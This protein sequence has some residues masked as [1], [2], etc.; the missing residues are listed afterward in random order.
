MGLR[1]TGLCD[2]GDVEETAAHTEEPEVEPETESLWQTVKGDF[3]DAAG[4]RLIGLVL[5]FS[6]MAFQ[7][8]WGN[9]IL[10][11]PIVVRAYEAVDDG[12]GWLSGFAAIASGVGAGSLFWALT[13]ALD[14]VVVLSGLRLMPGITARISRFLRRQ[15]W[16]K[17]Y[18]DISLGTRFLIAYL[19][20]ASALALVDVFATGQPGLKH[21]WRLI[22]DAVALA[23]AGVAF[24]IFVVGLDLVVG[25]RVP[26]TE[27]AADVVLRF[28]RNP[29]TWLVIYG[30]GVLISALVRRLRPQES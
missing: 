24:A 28:A 19:S 12:V 4:L 9:D 21:R 25:S 7:W 8:G 17:P 6:W 1:A 14:A 15:G 13:Q 18:A 16:V 11:P 26:A 3:A 30:G 27:G 22:A 5:L 23:V 2:S 10:L 20:G 29:L